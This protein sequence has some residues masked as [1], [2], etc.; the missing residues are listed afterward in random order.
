MSENVDIQILDNPVRA[1]TDAL[2]TAVGAGGHV[3]LTGG[4]TPK[5]AYELAAREQPKAFAGA[6]LWFGDD[7]CVAPDDE[8]SNYLM[9]KTAMLDPLV[10]A[11]VEIGFCERMEG[12]LGFEAG[13]DA[14]EAAMARAGFVVGSASSERFTLV[15][16]GIGPDTHIASM[17]PGQVSLS[18]RER[19]VV[20]VPEA[21]HDPY[22][23]R[24]TMTFPALALADHVIVL[25]TGA[26]K[27]E[28]VSAAFAPDAPPSD[29]VPASLLASHVERLTVMLDVEA[30]D[31]L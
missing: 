29:D 11:G 20:G 26:G 27:A 18:E 22:V 30:A 8:R 2:V 13:A 6:R 16:L 15:V 9:V 12:E 1:F 10:A 7:R 21:G 17:F 5:T 23:P 4:S 25:A 24:I 3:A 28:A 14:Y 31:R 19:L